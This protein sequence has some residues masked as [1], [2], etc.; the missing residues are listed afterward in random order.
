VTCRPRGFRMA[1]T[2]GNAASTPSWYL[3]GRCRLHMPRPGK[4]KLPEFLQRP[5][6][7]KGKEE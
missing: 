6:Q 3:A 2:T 7:G 1:H 5:L 4:I